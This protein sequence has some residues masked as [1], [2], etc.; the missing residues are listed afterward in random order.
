VKIIIGGAPVT[1]NFAAE[2]GADRYV[3]D[4]GAA[5]EIIRELIEKK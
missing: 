1:A 4:A 3:E 2:I 5:G